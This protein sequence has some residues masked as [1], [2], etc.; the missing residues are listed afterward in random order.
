[1]P[2][3]PGQSGNPAGRKPNTRPMAEI[4]RRVGGR[5][6][7]GKA[8]RQRLGE[9]MWQLATFGYVE[10]AEGDRMEAKELP[11]WFDAVKF[12][13]VHIDGPAKSETDVNLSG[14]ITLVADTEWQTVKQSD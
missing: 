12:I 4:L 8:N 14:G 10:F 5:R 9:M 6:V 3:K 11:D 7:D 2:W 1:M 13:Y